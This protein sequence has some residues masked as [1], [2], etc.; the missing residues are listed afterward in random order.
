MKNR[1]ILAVLLVLV[2]PA[3]I[4]VQDTVGRNAAQE[5]VKQRMTD[6]FR[7]SGRPNIPPKGSWTPRDKGELS[8]L[9]DE[10]LEKAKKHG[11]G[12]EVLAVLDCMEDAGN[13]KSKDLNLKVEVAWAEGYFKDAVKASSKTPLAKLMNALDRERQGKVDPNEPSSEMLIR[14]NRFEIASTYLSWAPFLDGLFKR[15][16]KRILES[17]AYICRAELP[18]GFNKRW[19]GGILGPTESWDARWD[20]AWQANEFARI[21]ELL[22]SIAN[23]HPNGLSQSQKDALIKR[24]NTDWGLPYLWVKGTEETNPNGIFSESFVNRV[25]AA[26]LVLSGQTVEAEGALTEV[27]ANPRDHFELSR[28]QDEMGTEI[29]LER[30]VAQG[31]I[32]LRDPHVPGWTLEQAEL[33]LSKAKA[34]LDQIRSAKAAE[35]AAEERA[36]ETAKQEAAIR[37][38]TAKQEASKQAAAR[39]S[40]ALRRSATQTATPFVLAKGG[41]EFVGLASKTNELAQGNDRLVGKAD[42]ITPKDSF[43]GKIFTSTVIRSISGAGKATFYLRP[44]TS[45]VQFVK[46]TFHGQTE[47]DIQSF[48][49]MTSAILGAAA[50]TN[51]REL[52]P[53]LDLWGEALKKGQSGIKVGNAELMCV[54]LNGAIFFIIHCG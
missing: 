39:Q 47:D 15:E 32:L 10:E 19:L 20:S 45:S 8:V 27:A 28:L 23:Y 30:L 3:L 52:K 54:N 35:K 50:G 22:K 49:R 25:K 2:G 42:K 21:C 5:V 46:T 7:N 16:I 4:A 37:E 17:D 36:K 48:V 38:K 18:D 51:Q 43:M 33:R 53:T 24:Q 11:K 44:G 31:E 41:I 26:R 29:A 34:K 12:S 1:G 13:L 14:V 6:Y 40:E 9:L